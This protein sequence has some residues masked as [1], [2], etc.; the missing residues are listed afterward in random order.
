MNFISVSDLARNLLNQSQSQVLKSR[1]VEL[2]QELTSG[3]VQDQRKHLGGDLSLVSSV[4]RAQELQQSY[5]KN[6]QDVEIIAETM[7]TALETIVESADQLIDVTVIGPQTRLPQV[8]NVAKFQAAE[9]IDTMISVLNTSV[10]GLYIFSGTAM[11]DQAVA[12]SETLLAELDLAITGAVGPAGVG[13]AVDAFFAPGG[14]YDTTIYTG[15]TTDIQNAKID[16][17]ESVDLSVRADNDAIRDSFRAA[18]YAYAAGS[19]LIVADFEERASILAAS[20][21]ATFSSKDGVLTLSANVGFAQ[22]RIEDAIVRLRVQ[23]GELQQTYA[24]LIGIDE[25][26]TATQ[27]EAVNTRLEMVYATT[28]RA[29]RLS[30]LEYLR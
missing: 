4:V 9:T 26:D 25:Y 2:T 7:Q 1:Q 27:L 18:A 6:N 3:V 10:S 5:I 30:F 23:D 12:S 28:V 15:S 14:T 19:D 22:Q 20:R 16:E 21:E 13:A 29:S 24:D 8:A 11:Q 17:R